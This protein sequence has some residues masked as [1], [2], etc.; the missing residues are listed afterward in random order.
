MV[1]EG[2]E[3]ANRVAP[4]G[5]GRYPEWMASDRRSL[6]RVSGW[7]ASGLAI[8]L[9]AAGCRR[10]PPPE[11]PDAYML[12]TWA[13]GGP[14]DAHFETPDA[15]YPDANQDA[16]SECAAASV[17]ALVERLPVDIIWVVDNSSSMAPAIAEVQSGMDAFARRLATS[18]LDYRLIVLSLRGTGETTISGSR[19]FQVCI[20]EPVAGP[21]CA[22]NAPRFYQIEVDIKSTQPLEQILGTLA[23][24]AGYTEGTERGG[25][26]WR[27]LLRPEA[28]KSIV[29]VTD[30]NARLCGGPRGCDITGSPWTC[31]VAGAM[32]FDQ[33]TDFETYPGGASPFSTTVQLGPGLLTGAYD[34][35]DSGPLFE[36]YTF[37]AIYGWGDEADDGV[38]CGTCGTSGAVVSSPGP[39]YSELVRH[40]GGVRAQIC[41]GPSAWGPFFEALATNVVETSRIDCEVAIPPPPDGMFF[42]ADQVNV[43]IRGRAGNTDVG[44]V[45][46]M[47]ACNP[48]TGGWYYDDEAAPTSITLCPVS[49]ELAREQV[50]TAEDGVDVAFGCDSVP[51]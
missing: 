17:G 49:C 5:D 3:S 41:D 11:A 4:T 9:A 47:A 1:R 24:T 26:P 6:H 23:Q 20:P 45:I 32:P 30:D 10:E 48:T 29:V 40:T 18:D 37:N 15:N 12:P 34:L 51:G 44:R 28:T 2:A 27:D 31:S 14:D 19:R 50:T 43:R 13:D 33:A 16:S 21:G 36:G 38:A 35:P 8:S 25:P 42:V 22:D 46:G 7:A 39:T